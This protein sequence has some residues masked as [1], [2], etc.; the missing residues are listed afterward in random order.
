MGSSTRRDD[1][2]EVL[3]SGKQGIAKSQQIR[4]PSFLLLPPAWDAPFKVIR[5]ADGNLEAA[6]GRQQRQ[7]Q[8][9]S[10]AGEIAVMGEEGDAPVGT[11]TMLVLRA[12]RAW[13]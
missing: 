10:G 8:T 2:T 11:G 4:E 3:I 12:E 13:P 1:T 7:H 9:Q 5:A 6:L